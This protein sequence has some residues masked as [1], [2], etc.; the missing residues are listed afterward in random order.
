LVILGMGAAKEAT[1]ERPESVRSGAAK[2]FVAFMGMRAPTSL[3]VDDRGG[4]KPERQ[5][6]DAE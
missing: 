1:I 3:Q 6:G 5:I 4:G 2:R